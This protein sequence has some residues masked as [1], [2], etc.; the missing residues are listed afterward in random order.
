V[1]RNRIFGTLILC[2][3]FF[4]FSCQKVKVNEWIPDSCQVLV[5]LNF[6]ELIS[7]KGH[8]EFISKV[9]FNKWKIKIEDSGLDFFQPAYFFQTSLGDQSGYF[10]LAGIASETSFLKTLQQLNPKGMVSEMADFQN[11]DLKDAKVVWQK[12]L[13]V[14]YF[15]NPITGPVFKNE[16]ISQFLVKEKLKRGMDPFASNEMISFRAKVE[17]E[18]TLPLLPPLEASISGN[19]Q[20]NSE[21]W[22]MDGVLKEGQFRTFLLPFEEPNFEEN[23][24]CHI[25]LALK[26]DLKKLGELLSN[27]FDIPYVE[28]LIEKLSAIDGPVYTSTFGCSQEE[29]QQNVELMAT[30]KN[31]NEAQETVDLYKK[32]GSIIRLPEAFKIESSGNRVHFSGTERK[33]PLMQLPEKLNSNALA[34]LLIKQNET[35]FSLVLQPGNEKDE[36]RIK[37]EITNPEKF[38]FSKPED[39]LDKLPL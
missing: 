24:N 26:P 14:F 20:L 21:K 35:H 18:N 37:L 36:T 16:A 15:F 13:C 9:I 39:F 2:L 10:L 30:Y 3:L 22:E 19:M 6:P 28:E 11:Y 12:N 17:E 38:D 5:R 32:L 4:Q 7:A 29:I 27:Y 34:K 31:L 25:K 1:S 23:E 33:R 8:Q